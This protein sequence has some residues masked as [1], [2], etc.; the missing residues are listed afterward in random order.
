[1]PRVIGRRHVHVRAVARRRRRD[2]GG[3][4]ARQRRRQ[5]REARRALVGDV[6]LVATEAP[7]AH[8]RRRAGQRVGRRLAREALRVGVARH[9]R[10]RRAEAVLG[11]RHA[12]P[13]PVDAGLSPELRRRRLAKVVRAQPPRRHAAGRRRPGHTVPEAALAGGQR[14][15]AAHRPGA[16]HTRDTVGRAQ[17]RRHAALRRRDDLRGQMAHELAALVRGCGLQH[18]SV[19][20]GPT[21]CPLLLQEG[22][23]AVGRCVRARLGRGGAVPPVAR[24]WRWRW[25]AAAQPVEQRQNRPTHQ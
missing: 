18:I 7:R 23:Q 11:A 5:Q 24:R 8:E 15:R 4:A 21:R 2:R 10:V 6:R 12:R 16:R 17:P 13:R 14:D 19:D 1:M 3:R 9:Q 20:G 25:L 22:G